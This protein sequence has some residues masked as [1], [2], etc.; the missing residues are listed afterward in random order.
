[1]QV[2][3]HGDRAAVA[4]DERG[5]FWS[6]PVVSS[7]NREQRAARDQLFVGDDAA[8]A[9]AGPHWDAADDHYTKAEKLTHTVGDALAIRDRAWAEIPYF[10]A[11]LARPLPSG[12]PSDPIDEEINGT[13]LHL[14]SAAHGLDATLASPPTTEAAAAT[15]SPPFEGEARDVRERLEHLEQLFAKECSRLEEVKH[16]DGS[17]LRDIQAVLD[18]SSLPARQREQLRQTGKREIA[19]KLNGDP[20]ASDTPSHGARETA[21]KSGEPAKNKA[22]TGAPGATA[23][24]AEPDGSDYRHLRLWFVWE[25][26]P[27]GAGDFGFECCRIRSRAD[28]CVRKSLARQAQ[29]KN[30]RFPRPQRPTRRAVA[31]RSGNRLHRL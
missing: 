7:G 17:T 29:L 14:I 5:Q 21:P 23:A 10:A 2:Q 22:A 20:I 25:Q 31:W 24:N 30:Q 12:E 26:H 9:A 8:I 6:L 3:A 11:W 28:R 16:G 15:E 13:L 1:M 19:N 27:K 4:D 18:V